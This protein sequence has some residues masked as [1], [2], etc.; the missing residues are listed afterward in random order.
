MRYSREEL[1]K[2]KQERLGEIKK[3]NEGYEMKIIEY[4]E[5]IDIMVEF[6]DKYKAKIHTNNSNFKKGNIKNP[7]HPSVFGVGYIGEGKYKSRGKDG[8]KTKAYLTWHSMIER[9]YSEKFKNTHPTYRDCIVCEEWHNF[10][11][12]AEWFY[13]HYY[14]IKGKTMHLD[15]D[16]LIKGNKINSPET[17]CL[18]PNDINTLFVKRQN[19]RGIY[20]IGVKLNKSKNKLEVT[21]STLE[22]N[23]YL[24]TFPL[25]RPFQAFTV[26]KNFKEK[27]IKQVADEYKYL[28]PK[29]LYEALYRYEVEIND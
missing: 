12:F 1:E 6:Q 8:K 28:I 3:S 15:K 22:K 17:C 25:N 2:Q 18:V 11:N 10:L 24:G 27:Y 23:E 13:K 16:I 20:P 14:E 9:G 21:C 29:E 19:D 5:Y 26:Y 7:Y 4:N